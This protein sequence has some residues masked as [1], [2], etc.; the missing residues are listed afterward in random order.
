M[1]SSVSLYD[2]I[3]Y[4]AYILWWGVE[5]KNPAENPPRK[6]TG[7]LG[8]KCFMCLGVSHAGKGNQIF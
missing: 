3:G 5:R 6:E 8:T 7:F 1:S 2:H 4:V